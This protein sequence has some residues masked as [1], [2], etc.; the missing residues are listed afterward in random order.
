MPAPPLS[1]ECPDDLVLTVVVP[2]YNEE[3]VL[4]L[5]V[6]RLRP[7]LDGLD[8]P[9]EV[10]AVDD[11]SSDSSPVLLQ[12]FRREW[13]ELRI[14]RLRANAG[15]QAAIS[16]GLMRSRG[17]YV[18][19]I[20]ADLQ[21]PPESIPIM[22]DLAREGQVDVVYGVRT[23]RSSDTAF[24]RRTAQAYYRIMR[25]AAGGDVPDQAGDYRLMSRA[26]VDAVNALPE[27]H[28]VLRLVVPTLG[29]PSTSVPYQRAA[30]AA[31]TSKYPLAKM[32]ALTVD[33]LTG[34]SMAPLRL[35]TWCGLLGGL[36][37]LGVLVYALVARA[38]GHV[39]AGWTSTVVAVSAV[40][41]VQ[42]LCLGVLG[43]Y[44]GRMYTMLQGRPTYYIA[45]DSREEEQRAPL[46]SG[47]H[48]S[49]DPV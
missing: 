35:A 2:V 42:L 24:K 9:Y 5:L 20:D 41:A 40:G 7:V 18:V 47:S 30:R 1:Q 32:L 25:A 17:D 12:R 6:E 4:P 39:I 48:P 11:G 49:Q 14:L 22:L 38:L 34:H 19:T 3:S 36:A 13:P 29:F 26:T 33:S 45:Y 31:G 16:A 46:R 8:S 44:V 21:D 23:D 28:R 10:V 43:E 15:H 37:A 27:Q